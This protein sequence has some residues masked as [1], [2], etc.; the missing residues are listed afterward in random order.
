MLL[1]SELSSLLTKENVTFVLAVIGSV[2]SIGE[3]IHRFISSRKR[4]NI[5]IL[6]FN[7]WKHV[8]QMLIYIQNQSQSSICISCISIIYDDKEYPCELVPKKICGTG[9]NLVCTPDF[10]LNL[11][12]LFGYHYF[13]EFVNSPDASLTPGSMMSLLVHTNR[14]VIKK[15]VK[16]D[17]MA[18][19]WCNK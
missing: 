1:I 5:K 14:G 3:L 9:E 17:D 4:I 11:T 2:G 12:P 10:P 18:H 13:L 7:Q 6:D 15:S 8:F 19:Y 16:L